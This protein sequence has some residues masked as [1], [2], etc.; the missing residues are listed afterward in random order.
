MPAKILRTDERKQTSSEDM[1]LYCVKDG[2]WEHA[3]VF[4]LERSNNEVLLV[5]RHDLD[6]RELS[7]SRL[8]LR[9]R[10]NDD[11]DD[12]ETVLMDVVGENGAVLK[13]GK[14]KLEKLE[15]GDTRRVG[16]GDAILLRGVDGKL[17]YLLEV[18]A[19]PRTNKEK[20]AK[21]AAKQFAREVEKRS[22]STETSAHVPK[23]APIEP[24]RRRALDA[25]A[26]ATADI[27]CDLTVGRRHHFE[28][29]SPS[30]SQN[31]CGQFDVRG[32]QDE[33]ES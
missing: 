17:H 28:G 11:D 4:S 27:S 3:V 25:A 30:R 22:R 13:K 2:E 20:E 9:F 7:L 33:R 19:V 15:K 23:A 5:G 21:Q 14:E 10:I 12:V 29:G 16:V 6:P 18:R 31:I 8:H 24:E 26:S 1:E 32:S